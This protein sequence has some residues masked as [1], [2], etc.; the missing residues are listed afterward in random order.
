MKIGVKK[1]GD[2]ELFYPVTILLLHSD[3]ILF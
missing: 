2:G 3:V 1:N